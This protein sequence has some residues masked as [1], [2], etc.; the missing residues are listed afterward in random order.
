MLIHALM[1]L[2]ND[3]AGWYPGMEEDT[4]YYPLRQYADGGPGMLE[5]GRDIDSFVSYFIKGLDIGK[6][7]EHDLS[8]DAM[9]ALKDLSTITAYWKQM[10][11]MS[12]SGKDENGKVINEMADMLD[13]FENVVIDCIKRIHEGI[14]HKRSAP[15]LNMIGAYPHFSISERSKIGRN[16]ACPCGSGKKYKKCCGLTH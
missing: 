11:P 6:T 8:G 16:E 1:E 14:K 12:V 15:H 10:E 3:I 5:R 7:T 13:K 4:F 9:D 2:W